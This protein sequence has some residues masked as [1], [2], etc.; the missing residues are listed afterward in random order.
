MVDDDQP[1]DLCRIRESW[2]HALEA[3]KPYALGVLIFTGLLFELFIHYFLKISVVYTQFY[4]LII[5]IAG[6]WYGRKA[7]WVA[8]FL[9]GLQIAVS[10]LIAGIITPESLLR[11]LLLVI[12]AY[13][14]GS[15]IELMNCYRDLL[16]QQNRNLVE[17]NRQLARSEEATGTANKKLSL[18]ASITRH[19]IR[20]QLM[21]LLAFLELSKMKVTDGEALSLLA[22]ADGAAQNIQRQ[23][24]FTKNYEEIGVRAPQW[25]NVGTILEGLRPR[26]PAGQV[27]LTIRLDGLE[28]Y[29][30]PL[31]V[32]VFEN[33]IDNSLRHGER[34]RHITVST[35]QYGLGEIA[36]EYADDGVGV[37]DDDKERIFEK[38]FGKNTGLGLFLIR[39]ILAITGLTMKESGVYEKGALFEI[40]IPREKYRFSGSEP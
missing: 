9:G 28:V 32:N 23:I 22:R 1:A 37:H 15:F 19:D 40:F 36:I 16:E 8:L 2:W 34:V 3:I 14:V 29:A 11:T 6:F 31:L 35:L 7:V 10:W 30:D 5:V 4:Y 27:G 12:V 20:N 33:L 18:L 13:V 21:A 25:Q 26:L 39:E 38:G 17:I 24:E